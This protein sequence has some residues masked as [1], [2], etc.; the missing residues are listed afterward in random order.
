M[1]LGPWERRMPRQHGLPIAG[2]AVF[3]LTAAVI[4]SSTC[5][6]VRAGGSELTA[7]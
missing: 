3:A 4:S 7:R 1:E 5:V 2:V 6:A